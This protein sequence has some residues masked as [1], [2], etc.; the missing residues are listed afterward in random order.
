MTSAVKVF[1]VKRVVVN[2]L[3]A[4]AIKIFSAHFELDDKNNPSH[5]QDNV[6]A[7]PH[8]WDRKLE[9][10]L[11]QWESQKS[12]LQNSDLLLPGILLIAL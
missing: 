6:S 7:F 2:L 5:D 4:G 11:T 3:N 8:P 9:V 10:D 1:E 12:R